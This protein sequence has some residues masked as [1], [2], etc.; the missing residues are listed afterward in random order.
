MG[1]GTAPTGTGG[2][3]TLAGAARER[4]L[5]GGDRGGVVVKVT[6]SSART[7]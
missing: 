6:E 1:G 5:L 7:G 4:A 3:I 2:G